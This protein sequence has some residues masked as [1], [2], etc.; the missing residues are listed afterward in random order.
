MIQNFEQL[1]GQLTE[2]ASIVNSFKSEAV[3]LRVVELIL[4]G[5]AMEDKTEDKAIV[6]P[7]PPSRKSSGRRAKQAAKENSAG[8]TPRTS[9]KPRTVG[10]A[11]LLSDLI[12]EGYFS[13]KH[14]ISDI[15]QYCG[16][17]KART[18]KANEVSSP[19]A[20]FVRDERLKREKNAD[21]NY[22]YF[23]P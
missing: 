6:S 7:V 20:R 16:T 3:Q 10:P 12:D 15:L 18:L 13:E 17:H 14:G 11:T 23:K 1:K 2:L 4:A 21:G 22:E 8:K 19:L 9:K 5:A